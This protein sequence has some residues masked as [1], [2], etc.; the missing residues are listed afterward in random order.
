MIY[1][2]VLYGRNSC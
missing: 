1:R 2:K